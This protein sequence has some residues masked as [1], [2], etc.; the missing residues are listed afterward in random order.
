[1][2]RPVLPVRHFIPDTSQPSDEGDAGNPLLDG[3]VNN[4]MYVP[5]VQYVEDCTVIRQTPLISAYPLLGSGLLLSKV[6]RAL[7][8]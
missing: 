4:G 5:Y 6:S 3:L 8:W 1:M 2:T 7:L